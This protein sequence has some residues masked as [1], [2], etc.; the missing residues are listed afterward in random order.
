MRNSDDSEAQIVAV[1]R[2]GDRG[3][4]AEE[5]VRQRGVRRPT[6]CRRKSKC[7]TA[8]VVELWELTTWEHRKT[9]PSGCGLT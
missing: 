1:R 5:L 9:C 3:V 7:G 4:R 8:G 2:D 6:F